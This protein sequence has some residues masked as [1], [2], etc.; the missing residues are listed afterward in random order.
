MVNGECDSQAG[1]GSIVDGAQL[2]QTPM[3]EY[4]LLERNEEDA[5]WSMPRNSEL[6]TFENIKELNRTNIVSECRVI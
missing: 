5:D 4:D 3:K 1:G 2:P 6:G